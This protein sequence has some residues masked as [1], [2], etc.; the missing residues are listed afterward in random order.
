MLSVRNILVPTDFSN[1][2]E[3]AL[4]L[5]V[6]IAKRNKAKITLLHVIDPV[7]Q[8]VADY[9]LPD[10]VVRS[11]MDKSVSET[12]AHFRKEA[13][14]FEKD[15]VQIVPDI[16][17]GVPYVEILNEQKDKRSDLIV[18]SAHGRTGLKKYFIGSVTD[19]VVNAA[20]CD[21]VV[22]KS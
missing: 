20:P 14:R 6:D 10:E 19:R 17:E 5:A 8:C 15:G 1:Y 7:Q 16:K 4:D 11:I 18:M 3:K 9:C 2:A 13:E 22:V 12:K 21:V